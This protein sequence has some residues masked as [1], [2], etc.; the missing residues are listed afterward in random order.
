[1]NLRQLKPRGEPDGHIDKPDFD[2]DSQRSVESLWE[3][4]ADLVIQPRREPWA[5]SDKLRGSVAGK[6]GAD[7]RDGS[8]GE[9][10]AAG[11]DGA[12][13]A[14]GSSALPSGVIVMSHLLSLGAGWQL[15][16]GTNG[17]PDLRDKFI[18]AAG[19]AYAASDTGGH[20]SYYITGHYMHHYHQL[21]YTPIDVDV[22]V[23]TQTIQQAAE[24]PPDNIVQWGGPIAGRP[25]P[26]YAH[27]Y[28]DSSD[29][30]NHIQYFDTEPETIDGPSTPQAFDNRPQF[31]AL[32]FHMKL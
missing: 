17:T 22:S 15:C 18:V 28:P 24:I 14:D 26:S 32:Y 10:G 6:S 9:D 7:G 23:P 2:E 16:D 19:A 30:I 25:Y 21:D 13:G 31:H 12:P 29:R 5:N 11:A 8:S 3:R 20:D 1:M 27:T 4:H